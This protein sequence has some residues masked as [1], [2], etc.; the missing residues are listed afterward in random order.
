MKTGTDNVGILFYICTDST[1]LFSIFVMDFRK[2][3]LSVLLVLIQ[4][5]LI[6]PTPDDLID[7]DSW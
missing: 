5:T 1:V 3:D 7:L 2:C 4:G 6:K